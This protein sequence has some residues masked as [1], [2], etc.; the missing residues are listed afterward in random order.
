MSKRH[1]SSD[2][3]YTTA[4]YAVGTVGAACIGCL[5]IQTGQSDWF[6]ELIQHIIERIRMWIAFA[7]FHTPNFGAF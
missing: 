4:E 1:G 7:D 3:G 2:A 6:I 5:L